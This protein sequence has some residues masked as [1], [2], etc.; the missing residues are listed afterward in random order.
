MKRIL[1]VA[2]SSAALSL[3]APAIA[4]A[5]HHAKRH[6]KHH[7]ARARVLDFRASAAP[8]TGSPTTPATPTTP[9]SESAGKIAS[10]KEGVLTITLTDGT[11]VSGKVTEQTQIHCSTPP[12]T[13]AEDNDDEAGSGEGDQGSSGDARASESSRNL[14]RAADH[15]SGSDDGGGGD[16]GQQN[17]TTSALTEGAP[18]SEAELSIGSG[19]AVWDKV[20]LIQ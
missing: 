11:P 10:F 18:V 14:A 7:G 20:D 8:T 2:V 16:E 12:T 3:A 5:H 19:G 13:G 1:M 4:S 15:G 6:H 17:C 9:T